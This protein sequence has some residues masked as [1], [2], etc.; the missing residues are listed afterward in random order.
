[1]FHTID[2]AV[3][4]VN[5]GKICFGLESFKQVDGGSGRAV[6]L[7]IICQKLD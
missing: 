5:L 6:K 3:V 7:Q 2:V 4:V 1:M